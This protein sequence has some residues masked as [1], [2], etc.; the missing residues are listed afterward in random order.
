[1][2]MFNRFKI[3]PG[4]L[5]ALSLFTIGTVLSFFLYMNNS[6]AEQTTAQTVNGVSITAVSTSS[7]PIVDDPKNTHA[8]IVIEL[9]NNRD[10]ELLLSPGLSFL[11]KTSTGT[12][13]PLTL[14]FQDQTTVLGGVIAPNQTVNLPLDFIVPTAQQVTSL[15]FQENAGAESMSLMLSS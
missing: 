14:Q 8:H 7:T 12:A 4:C 5:T 15:L 13:Y 6:H 1:M 11:L 10:S 2:I 3:T 9:S